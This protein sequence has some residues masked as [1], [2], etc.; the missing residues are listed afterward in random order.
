M[1]EIVNELRERLTPPQ[2]KERAKEVAVRETRELKDRFIDSPWAIGITGGLVAAGLGRW[3][4]GRREM[5]QFD[6]RYQ[7]AAGFQERGTGL[8]E[9]GAQL[10]DKASELAGG[11]REK[12]GEL[13][14][15]AG[16]LKDKAVQMSHRA[17]EK[18]PTTEDVKRVGRY[19][20]EE[21]L[22]GALAA[23]AVGAALGL[24]LPLTNKER[25]VLE[26]YR[27]RAGEKLEQLTEDVKEQVEGLSGK[28]R[29]E[30]SEAEPLYPD[31]KPPTLQ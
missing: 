17:V 7:S 23:V 25:E 1:K 12:A 28:I 22:V 15:K 11:V 16:E 29:G 13:K 27:V 6:T 26:P 21:P 3:L 20:G 4:R 5:R 31:P 9:R 8:Q 19:V 14:E 24:L 2:L 18:L 30:E 10:R